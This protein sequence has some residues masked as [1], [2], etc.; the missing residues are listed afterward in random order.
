[1]IVFVVLPLVFSF[2]EACIGAVLP[3]YPPLPPFIAL[4]EH[5]SIAEIAVQNTATQPWIVQ[6]LLDLDVLRLKE[7][8]QG[9]IT[10]Q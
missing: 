9:R 7:M 2:L 6:K 3:Q 4:E 1:M 10:K 8:D 5:F